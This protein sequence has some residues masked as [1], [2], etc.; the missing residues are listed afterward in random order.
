MK[1]MYVIYFGKIL[2]VVIETIPNA[3]IKIT[4]LFSF[5]QMAFLTCSGHFFVFKK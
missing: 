2:V 4:R 1:Y 5:S 3:K